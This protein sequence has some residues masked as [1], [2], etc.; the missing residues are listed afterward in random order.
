MNELLE[1]DW[2]NN[3]NA[4]VKTFKFK[5]FL[6]TMSFANAIAWEANRQNHHPDMHITFNTCTIKLTTHDEGN[7]ITDKDIQLALSIEKI[8]ET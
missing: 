8:L 1:K 5:G 6:K 3:D 4:L 7:T 2:S